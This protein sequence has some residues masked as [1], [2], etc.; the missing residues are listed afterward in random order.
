ML[1]AGTPQTSLER[2]ATQEEHMQIPMNKTNIFFFKTGTRRAIVNLSNLH[3]FCILKARALATFFWSLIIK[4]FSVTIQIA[5]QHL[6]K[7]FRLT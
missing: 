4:L 7:L 6:A 5:R 1:K 3:S 2:K